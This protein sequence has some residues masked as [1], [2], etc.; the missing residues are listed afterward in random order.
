MYNYKVK[1]LVPGDGGATLAHHRYVNISH[2]E[3]LRDYSN[4]DERI[5]V[6]KAAYELGL[7]P[8]C[9]KR[10]DGGYWLEKI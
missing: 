8:S 7:D 4:E 5:A 9:V 10:G 1:V 6:A 3:K 2:S